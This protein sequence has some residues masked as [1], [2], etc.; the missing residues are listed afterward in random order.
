MAPWVGLYHFAILISL[1]I[2]DIGYGVPLLSERESRSRNRGWFY[3]S[4]ELDA[5]IG[6][7]PCRTED[8][9]RH[10]E[11]PGTSK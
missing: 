1:F 8:I 11:S 3:V 7:C 10:D 9:A 4:G 2:D 5:I 6:D